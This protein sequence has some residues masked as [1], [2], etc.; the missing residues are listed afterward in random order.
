MRTRTFAAFGASAVLALGVTACGSDDNTDSTTAASGAATSTAAES[1]PSFTGSINAGGSTFAKPVY[2]TWGANLKAQGLSFNY[3]GTG[4]GA[5]IA[6]VTDGTLDFGGS[7]SATDDDELK[8]AEKKN[9]DVLN[10]PMFFGAVTA[11]YNVEGVKTGLKLDGET[12]ANIFLGDVT[13]WNDKQIA[14]QNPGVTLPSSKITVVHRSDESGTTKAFL[15]YLGAYSKK[16]ED[17]PGVDKSVKWPTG[18]GAKGNDGVAAAIKQTPNSIGYVEQAYAL[19]NDFTYASLKNKA[20]NYVDPTLESVS[21][22]GDSVEVPADLR[23]AIGNAEG[24]QTYPDASA[25]FVVVAK[26]LCKAGKTEAVAKDI[27]GFLTYGLAAGQD[28]AK[29]L[30]YAPL[31]DSVKTKAQAAVDSLECNGAP[32]AATR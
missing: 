8:A 28:E 10:I 12:L 25:T 7:D 2:D 15:S 6:G 4:S 27:K 14:D 21:A 22:A 5:G 31:P 19:N 32:I 24:D 13:T 16:W 11:S 23:F 30:A 17:G 29:K 9:G 3:A 26:D 1:T 20:G 18:T